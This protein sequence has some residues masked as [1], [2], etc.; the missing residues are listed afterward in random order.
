MN[1]PLKLEDRKYYRAVDG[2]VT[3]VFK[4]RNPVWRMDTEFTF[5]GSSEPHAAAVYTDTG[6]CHASSESYSGFN[7]ISEFNPALDCGHNFSDVVNAPKLRDGSVLISEELHTYL[8]TLITRSARH[9]R[10]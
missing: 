7:L 8:I 3:Q 2:T 4:V 6:I 10:L 9:I 1:T 5:S